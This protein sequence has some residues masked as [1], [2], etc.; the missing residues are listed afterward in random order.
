MHRPVLLKE[1]IDCLD[2][3]T[4]E[5]FIDATFGEGGHARAIL[6]KTAPKGK[7]LGIEQDAALIENWKLKIENY[8]NRLVLVNDNFANLEKIVEKNK[9]N[10][11]SGVLLDLGI[12]SWH[13]DQ[14]QRGFSFAKNEPLDMRVGKTDLTAREIVNDWPEEKIRKILEDYS[15]ERFARQIAQ[16]VCR[17]RE[18]GPIET[19]LQLVEIIKRAV[20]RFYERG[21]IHQ[22]T[23]TF[24]ALRI[25]V[26]DELGN[27][28]RVLP[29]T[30]K[31]LE[32]SG[33]LAVISFNSRE[34]K[35]VKN[36]LKEEAQKD[37]LEIL[38]KKPVRPSAEEIVFNP[39]ARSGKLRAA[40]K[41]NQ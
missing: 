24:L 27:L 12:S 5:N 29:Q 1:V 32:P 2:P 15:Q 20:P 22:A 8:Q 17:Q 34:D 26:N 33:R 36:F 7:L 16:A 19:T 3:K 30:L 35:I 9:F 39:R 41:T 28:S 31:I 6:E 14:S 37:N 25:A 10:N 13:F 4:N 18:I 38:T 23:R 40:K 21:R 11:V